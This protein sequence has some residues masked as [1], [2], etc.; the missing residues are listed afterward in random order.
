MNPLTILKAF[1]L[2][3]WAIF[4]LLLL[5][6]LLFAHGQGH[7]A[8]AATARADL[9]SL[10]AAY[11]AA[12]AEG[13]GL[14]LAAQE[15]AATARAGASVARRA[16]SQTSKEELNESKRAAPSWSDTAVPDGVRDALKAARGRA[17]QPAVR[18]APG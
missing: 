5:C 17:A 10:K 13:K 9:A 11:S 18:D 14:A 3:A 7:R 1:D 8:D 12:E 15:N 16:Q 4:G 6:G 2:K